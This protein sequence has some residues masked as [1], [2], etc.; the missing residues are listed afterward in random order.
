[1]NIFAFLQGM[2]EFRLQFT[3]SYGDPDL[4]WSYD[5]GREF[6]HRLTFRRFEQS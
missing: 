4:D 5:M 6:A 3:L 1:M 2:R